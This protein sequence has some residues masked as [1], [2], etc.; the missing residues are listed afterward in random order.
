MAAGATPV[1]VSH[2]RDATPKNL[3]SADLYV[4]GIGRGGAGRLMI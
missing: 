4:C 2:I 1:T 3:P